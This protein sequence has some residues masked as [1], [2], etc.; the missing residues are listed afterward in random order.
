MSSPQHIVVVGGGLGGIS[1]CQELRRGGY[2]GPLTLLDGG[3]VLHDRPPLSKDFLLGKIDADG[4]R[5]QPDEWF[6]EQDITVRTATRVTRVAP[7]EGWVELADGE[8]LEADAVVLATG[9]AARRLPVPGGER[10]RVLRDLPDA[11]HLKSYLRPGSRVLVVG[12][13]LIGAE[14]TATARELG[15]DVV[16]CDPMLPL[17]N[18]VGEE[19]A[20]WLHG[21]HTEHGVTVHSAGVEEITPTDD[22]LRACLTNHAEVDADIIVAGIGMIPETAV[23][24]ASGAVVDQGVVVDPEQRT[25]IPGLWAIGDCTRPTAADGTL[26][27]RVEHW[28][29]AMH[30]A[31]RAAASILG[32]EAP[33]QGSEWFWSDRY[34]HHL[35]VVGHPTAGEQVV[36]GTVGQPPFAVLAVDDGHLVGALSVDDPQTVR[37]ARR[38]LE[39]GTAVTAAELADPDVDLRKLARRR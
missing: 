21:L 14:L 35:E 32:K 38:L 26:L 28:E 9:G 16:L 8:R 6:A 37:A 39:R 23:A 4:I 1:V 36:R 12:G 11:E 19:V 18:V 22:G 3:E 20:T 7:E 33:T 17:E 27:P 10:V 34:G 29:G 24:E 13:G 25:S 30:A 5:L 31:A 2:S 15:A